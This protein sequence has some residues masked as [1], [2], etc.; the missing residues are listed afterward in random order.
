MNSTSQFR[1]S[2]FEIF[3]DNTAC[4][5]AF[6]VAPKTL[7]TA[8]HC[9]SPKTE[10][11]RLKSDLDATS[12]ARVRFRDDAQDIA[13]LTS[14]VL[15]PPLLLYEGD[16][17]AWCSLATFGYP[18]VPGLRGMWGSA[19]FLGLTEV[20]GRQQ[21]QLRSNEITLGFSGAP[22]WG[23]NGAVGMVTSVIGPSA[24]AFGATAKSIR[25]S[26]KSAGIDLS[27]FRPDD[28]GSTVIPE[29][30]KQA[31]ALKNRSMARC[32]ARWESLG[33]RRD[34]ALTLANDHSVGSMNI[35]L[36]DLIGRHLTFIVG[37]FGVGKSL[38]L[39]RFLQ[40]FAIRSIDSSV[41]KIYYADARWTPTVEAVLAELEQTDEPFGLFLDNAE[42][43]GSDRLTYVLEKLRAL[44][45]ASP[46]STMIVTSRPTTQLQ[47]ADETVEMPLFPLSDALELLR[48]LD[49]SELNDNLI[50][51][52]TEVL[53]RPLFV[54]LFAVHLKS[55]DFVRRPPSRGDLLTL[56]AKSAYER[57]QGSIENAAHT[58]RRL[59]SLQIDAGGGLV[60]LNQ[61]VSSTQQKALLDSGLITHDASNDH[62]GFTLPILTQWFAAQ[63]LEL[64]EIA[65]EEIAVEEIAVEEIAG[66]E[67][68]LDRWRYPLLFFFGMASD[69]RIDDVLETLT[70]VSPGFVASLLHQARGEWFGLRDDNLPP[71]IECGRRLRLAAR[72]WMRAIHPLSSL[73]PLAHAGDVAKI[74]VSVAGN[75]LVVGW[76]HGAETRR[77]VFELEPGFS[78]LSLPKQFQSASYQQTVWIHPTWTWR[79][80][81]EAVAKPLLEL[82]RSRNCIAKGSAQE[83]EWAWQAALGA[84]NRGSLALDPVNL[85]ALRS[86]GVLE[87]DAVRISGVR[88][89]STAPLKA[90]AERFRIQGATQMG[91][92][93]PYA[94][95][96]GEELRW[97]WS[98]FSE[99]R[100]LERIQFVFAEAIRAYEALVREYFPSFAARMSLYV[101]LPIEYRVNVLAV[102][103]DELGT[104]PWAERYYMPLPH[105]TPSRVTVTRSSEHVTDDERTA[106]RLR[107][108]WSERRPHACEGMRHVIST[109]ILDIFGDFPISDLVSQ[110]LVDDLSVILEGK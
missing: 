103:N 48:R 11:L 59:A 8:A 56:M 39:E 20:D 51:D 41:R 71:A 14:E 79:E 70:R 99:A 1:S 47:P 109:G 74:G 49:V 89:I 19:T 100:L 27:T 60:P 13:W 9:L 68:Q 23:D 2:V 38:A 35:S 58:L 46:N 17:R 53:E 45:L 52:F 34:V 82:A 78:V 95:L 62:V 5:T 91:P 76:Y 104:P 33:V 85:E 65:V 42:A 108:L 106:I 55:L 101:A 61:V 37:D 73:S 84:L 12:E 4:G 26:A 72:A 90:V 43:L 107:A 7:V 28:I 44:R 21:L 102:A 40:E 75:H 32:I 83:L 24:T 30:I 69:D 80:M 66:S 64:K 110:W 77:D 31:L 18:S 86:T 6:V 81:L 94:D 87:T 54:I 105:G 29:S 88:L 16:L 67:Q 63:R 3:E 96:Q 93:W 15:A 97:V 98:G 36:D 92:P 57:L 50:S 10:A 25:Q 22:L